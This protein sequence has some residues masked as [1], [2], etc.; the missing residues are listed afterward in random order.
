[1]TSPRRSSTKGVLVLA[2]GIVLAALIAMHDLVPT[3][4]GLALIVDSLLPWSWI[5]IALLLLIAL[6]RLSLLSIAGVLVPVVVWASLF[7]NTTGPCRTSWGTD[8]GSLTTL[9]KQLEAKLMWTTS[10]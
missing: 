4:R 10:T 1:M 3:T 5:P 6:F 2:C 9:P 8:L 7:W